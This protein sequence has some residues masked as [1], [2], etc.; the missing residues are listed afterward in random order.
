M[1]LSANQGLTILEVLA[2]IAIL[3]FGLL[4]IATMQASSIKGN[5]HA[6]GLTEAITLAQDKVEEIL[7]LAYDDPTLADG[8][9]TNDGVAGL[10]DDLANSDEQDPNNPIQV[11]GRGRIFNVYWNVVDGDPITN[12][13]TV[14]VFVEWT[15]KGKQRKASVDHL[16]ADIF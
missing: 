16:K 9:G 11:G 14:R 5:A 8:D 13:K 3:S 12:T 4:A 15:E 2:A 6:I 7:P 1:R 10:N